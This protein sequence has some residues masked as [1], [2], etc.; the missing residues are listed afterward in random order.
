MRPID[1]A[2]ATSPPAEKKE[3]LAKRITSIDDNELNDLQSL[4]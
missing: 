3:L 4:V 1:E 2:L